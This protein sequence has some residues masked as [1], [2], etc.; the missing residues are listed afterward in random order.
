M[1]ADLIVLK[2]RPFE[3]EEFKHRRTGTLGGYSVPVASAED[4]I[5]AKLEWKRITPSERQWQDACNVAMAQ[6]PRLDQEYLRHW[7][8]ELGI[9][10]ELKELLR[11]AEQLQPPF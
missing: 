2:N 10:A 1:K 11:Q 8:A 9:T 3:K 7:A 4:I 6:W 5:L